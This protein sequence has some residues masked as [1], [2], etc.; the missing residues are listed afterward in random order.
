MSHPSAGARR[1]QS[2]A[3]VAFDRPGRGSASGR[4]RPQQRAGSPR[5]DSPEA[6]DGELQ[7]GPSDAGDQ[8]SEALH[9]QPRQATRGIP[10][11]AQADS[12]APRCAHQAPRPQ[13][14]LRQARHIELA[15]PGGNDHQALRVRAGGSAG[16]LGALARRR[17]RGHDVRVGALGGD[18]PAGAASRRGGPPAERHAWCPRADTYG[19]L[20]LRRRRVAQRPHLVAHR[21]ALPGARRAGA[22]RLRPAFR[23]G[24][25]T[26]GGTPQRRVDVRARTPSARPASLA[27]DHPQAGQPASTEK[28]KGPPPSRASGRSTGGRGR[29]G[30][31]QQRHPEPA[32]LLRP[33]R[34][35][36]P[37]LSGHDVAGPR[38]R[39]ALRLR[40]A[41]GAHRAACL[42]VP[43]RGAAGRA[44]G[45]D[46]RGPGRRPPA[47]ARLHRRRGQQ[48]QPALRG[49]RRG[50]AQPGDLLPPRPDAETRNR[51]RRMD[52]DRPARQGDRDRT[53]PGNRPWHRADRDQ[54]PAGAAP[55]GV[56]RGGRGGR[57]RR[58]SVPP[59]HGPP[60]Q[61][62]GTARSCSDPPR[63]E[64]SRR[65]RPRSTRIPAPSSGT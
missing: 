10:R 30:R 3:H 51:P 49:L 11:G 5:R 34:H 15:R 61:S 63:P 14:H 21:P 16:R 20:D 18:P 64:A 12:D 55:G 31:L 58:R 17:P 23:R 27:A 8:S 43:A 7:A 45:M 13:R 24:W 25:G 59:L 65:S 57:R 28:P 37:S 50:A 22:C 47:D 29:T 36:L 44:M 56:A 19:G 39:D 54:D 32:P 35:R 62:P 33:R 41:R 60:I 2:R 26:P 46:D 40:A 48:R 52:G 6:G 38:A 1:R 53:V 42:P 9:L 4:H